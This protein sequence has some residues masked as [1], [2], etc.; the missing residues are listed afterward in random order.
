MWGLG[1]MLTVASC[2]FVY[3]KY[4]GGEEYVMVVSVF[5]TGACVLGCQKCRRSWGPFSTVCSLYTLWCLY[6]MVIC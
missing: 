6:N 4:R 3:F 1:L 5:K 2:G